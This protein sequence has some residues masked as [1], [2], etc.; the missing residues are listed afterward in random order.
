MQQESVNAAR[1]HKEIGGFDIPAG[2]M[3]AKLSDFVKLLFSGRKNGSVQRAHNSS[4]SMLTHTNDLI[5][6]RLMFRHSPDVLKY[7]FKN[8]ARF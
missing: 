2:E 4:P 6:T 3:C 8:P 5:W 7:F 1:I